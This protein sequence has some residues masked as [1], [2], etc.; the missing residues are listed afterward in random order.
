MKIYIVMAHGGD[1]HVS[2]A[3]LS[4][5]SALKHQRECE[6]SGSIAD[7]SNYSYWSYKIDEIELEK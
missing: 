7:G 3:D 1:S 4:K 2:G 6:N 5:E